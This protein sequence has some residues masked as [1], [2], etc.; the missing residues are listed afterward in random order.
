MM[1][2]F[3]IFNMHMSKLIKLYTLN[4]FSLLYLNYIL[5]KLKKERIRKE[6]QEQ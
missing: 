1:D 3:I 2:I 5:I 4:M 6:V